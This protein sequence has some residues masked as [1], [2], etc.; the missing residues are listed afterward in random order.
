MENVEI[1]RHIVGQKDP[2]QVFFHEITS[3]VSSRNTASDDTSVCYR[4]MHIH[5]PVVRLVELRCRP[6][7]L[8]VVGDMTGGNSRYL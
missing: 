1:C 6:I 5:C 7:E 4:I 2:F 3:E 8:V